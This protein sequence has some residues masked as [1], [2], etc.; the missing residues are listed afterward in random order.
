M[1]LHFRV[2]LL[3]TMTTAPVLASE[4]ERY[5]NSDVAVFVRLCS[6][7][8]SV[9]E[10]LGR[11][12]TPDEIKKKADFVLEQKKLGPRPFRGAECHTDDEGVRRCTID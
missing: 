10:C 9:D 1:R 3:M 6:T 11:I 8:P 2:I 5:S 4:H 12:L 7:Q